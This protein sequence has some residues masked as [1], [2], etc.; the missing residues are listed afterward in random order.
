MRQDQKKLN[1]IRLSVALC[2]ES[3]LAIKGPSKRPMCFSPQGRSVWVFSKNEEEEDIEGESDGG[4]PR[5]NH[6]VGKLRSD[7][8]NRPNLKSLLSMIQVPT[9]GRPQGRKQE[10]NECEMGPF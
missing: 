4:D 7:R 6:G 8:A 5:G 10:T 9:G 3:G 1:R 2:N